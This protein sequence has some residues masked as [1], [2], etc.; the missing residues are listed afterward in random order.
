MTV[1]IPEKRTLIFYE[2]PHRL[3][4]TLKVMEEIFPKRHLVAARELTKQY[5]EVLRGTPQELLAY[6]QA[7]RPR[8][9]FTLLLE[10]GKNEVKG[11][12]SDEADPLKLVQELEKEGLD[13]R[14]AIRE[15]AKR[16][17]VAKR[18]VY[19]AVKIS[20]NDNEK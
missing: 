9:E 18:E 3:V 11:L 10:G 6:F 8:G 2:A 7:N 5:E 1:L 20:K 16:L 15:A 17:G 12:P 19:Q 14:E 13:W 4:E